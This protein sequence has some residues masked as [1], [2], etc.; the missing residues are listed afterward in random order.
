MVNFNTNDP[1]NNT[2]N[3]ETKKETK[4]LSLNKEEITKIK[5][6]YKIEWPTWDEE[7]ASDSVLFEMSETHWSSIDTETWDH[8]TVIIVTKVSDQSGSDMSS[9]P[10]TSFDEELKK[11]SYNKW[12][13]E[14]IS[15]WSG[16]CH[17][18]FEIP[19]CNGVFQYLEASGDTI[20]KYM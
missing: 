4:E 11:F 16:R 2:E 5:E 10:H 3:P 18:Y 15:S 20:D 14:W 7:T 19:G 1:C 17:F 13:E 8:C 6:H 12:A 9:Y